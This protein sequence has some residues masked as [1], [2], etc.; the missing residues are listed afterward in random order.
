MIASRIRAMAAPHW[1]TLFAL[2]LMGWAALFAMAAPQI[3]REGAALYGSE[4]WAGLC[5]LTPD[6]AGFARITLMWVLMSAAMMAPT[7]LPA[8]ATYD[9]LGHTTDTKFSH[10]VGGYLLVWIGFSILAAAL[11]FILFQADLVSALGDSRSSLFSGLLL[12]AAGAYHFTPLKEACLSKCRAPLTF[13]MSH[14]ADGPF[15]MGLRLGAVCVGCCAALMLLAFV[16]GVMNL[17]F[18]GLATILMILEKLPEL[19]RYITR[20]LGVSLMGAGLWLGLIGT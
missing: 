11:Q 13:F 17:A 5:T 20:P 12:I 18:M 4:F 16:G 2:I 6:A 15:A 19:G 9:D 10:L 7:A 1:L 8:F 14:W 3:M